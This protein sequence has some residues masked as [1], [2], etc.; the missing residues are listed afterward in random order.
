[1]VLAEILIKLIFLPKR[2]E[3]RV[4]LLVFQ[5]HFMAPMVWLRAFTSSSLCTEACN[6]AKYLLFYT[7]LILCELWMR[8]TIVAK[9]VQIFN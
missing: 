3:S 4:P 5:I 1:M 9:L 6:F 7:Y 8:M 2:K